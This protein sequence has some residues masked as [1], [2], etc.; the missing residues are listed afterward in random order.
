MTYGEAEYV[1]T[2]RQSG[3]KVIDFYPTKKRDKHSIQRIK[4][5]LIEGKHDILHLYTGIAITNGIPAAKRL[6]VKIVLYRGYTGNIHWYDPSAYFKYLSRHVDSVWCIADATRDLIKRNLIF[7]QKNKPVSITKGH[8]PK[9]YQGVKKAD[10]SDLNL[11]SN[12]FIAAHVSNVRPMKGIPY[13]IKATYY[14][15]T[16]LPIYFLFAGKGMDTEGI[17]EL[18]KNS[19]NKDKIILLGYRKDAKNIVK[20]SHTFLLASIKGEAICKAVIEAM[21][22]G[23]CPII[24]D[25]PGNRKLVVHQESGL[26]VPAKNPKALADA[27]LYAYHQPEAVTLMAKNA[28]KRMQQEFHIDDTVEQIFEWYGSLRLT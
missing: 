19:P 5:T 20:A 17:P 14:L 11:P 3:I 6:P 2:F 15:P 27:I 18:I 10:L 7:F 16:D 8:D 26:V 28:Q 25:I 9:W 1:K 24:T 23:I 4:D 22:L 21:S 12:A 13:L